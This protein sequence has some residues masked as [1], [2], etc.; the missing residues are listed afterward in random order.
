[1][2]AQQRTWLPSAQRMGLGAISFDDLH[3]AARR[4]RGMGQANPGVYSMGGSIP[5]AGSPCYDP[6]AGFPHFFGV[7]SASEN[8]CLA[9]NPSAAAVVLT[10]ALSTALAPGLPVGYDPATGTIDAS[11][12]SGATASQSNSIAAAIQ[13]QLVT[14]TAP[15][16]AYAPSTDPCFNTIGVS[17]LSLGL[18]AGAIFLGFAL[19]KGVLR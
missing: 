11:N 15:G 12:T 2:Y 16:G 18:M 9:Q 17:C 8:A 7:A 3:R 19:I 1:M 10:P 4:S 14:A 6:N 13:S 5:P